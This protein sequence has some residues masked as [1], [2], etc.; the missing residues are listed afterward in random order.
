MTR[1]QLAEPSE[2]PAGDD[3]LRCR[4]IGPAEYYRLAASVRS[5]IRCD[6]NVSGMRGLQDLET[7]ERFFVDETD[8]LEYRVTRQGRGSE[9]DLPYSRRADLSLTKI[10]NPRR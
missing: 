2:I 10:E 4:R 7:G 3:R 6:D 8:L 5:L 1:F 9:Y